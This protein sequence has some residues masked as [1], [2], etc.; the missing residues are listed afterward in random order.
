VIDSK[1]LFNT[2]MKIPFPNTPD[3]N[4]T[5]AKA[6]FYS[7]SKILNGTHI[8]AAL[9]INT[10]IPPGRSHPFSFAAASL[11]ASKL[12]RSRVNVL[13]FASGTSFAIRLAA[14]SLFLGERPARMM[15]LG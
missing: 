14:S 2:I 15:S 1:C 4:D 3:C 8:T 11:T 7:V 9:L 10:S 13:V 12:P 6:L 5:L